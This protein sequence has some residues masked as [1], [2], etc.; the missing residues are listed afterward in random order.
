MAPTA[1]LDANGRL[2]GPMAKSANHLP[3]PSGRERPV[4]A[5]GW[6]GGEAAPSLDFRSQQEV[7]SFESDAAIL[8]YMTRHLPGRRAF[9]AA[10]FP[11][12]HF[13]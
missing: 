3:A 13:R 11:L 7:P 2:A 5:E 6:G 12:T 8:L 10:T 9:F 4:G 1:A